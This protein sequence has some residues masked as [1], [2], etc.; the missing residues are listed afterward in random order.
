MITI[1]DL[2]RLLGQ[3]PVVGKVHPLVPLCLRNDVRIVTDGMA[4]RREIDLQPS[5]SLSPVLILDNVNMFDGCFPNIEIRER[6]SAEAIN[7]RLHEHL[8]Y[9]REHLITTRTIADYVVQDASQ[10]APQIIVL[11]LVDGLSY[12]DA[13]GWPCR[14][15]PCFVDGVSV[16]FRQ[17]HDDSI[18]EHIGFPAI[19]GAPSIAQRLYGKGYTIARGYSYWDRRSGNAAS[20]YLF[21]GIPTTQTMNFEAILDSIRREDFRPDELRFIQIVREGLDGLAHNKRELRPVEIEASTQAIW[22]DA[23]KLLEVL[24]AKSSSVRIYLT[25]DHGVLWKHE[26]EFRSIVGTKTGHP[27]YAEGKVSE[28]LSGLGAYM[29]NNGSAYTL[30]RYPYLGRS[31]P[32]DHSGVH[33]GLSYQ[34]SITPLAILE[35]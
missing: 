35:G 27:R 14:V 15:S 13:V 3:T 19:V 10:Y 31:I 18:M 22:R 33:G 28:S 26:H 4:F 8:D 16:T 2:D 29:E 23:V 20:D 17:R 21:R 5:H 32:S 12:E 11:L 24:R 25:A 9:A 34:E 7:M 30:L 6:P 1:A